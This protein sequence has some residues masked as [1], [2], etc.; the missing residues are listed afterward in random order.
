M[1]DHIKI[2]CYSVHGGSDALGLLKL[3]GRYGSTTAIFTSVHHE[4]AIL[5]LLNMMN[6]HAA[7]AYVVGVEGVKLSR[8]LIPLFKI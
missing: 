3:M 7:L 2:F 8:N 6:F 1:G 5:F 4:V